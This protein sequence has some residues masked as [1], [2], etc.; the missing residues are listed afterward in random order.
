[1]DR[2]E[3][4]GLIDLRRWKAG[5]GERLHINMATAATAELGIAGVTTAPLYADPYY[6]PEKIVE[7]NLGIKSANSHNFE[8][9]NPFCNF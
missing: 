7:N 4:S 9:F 1:M 8:F 6:M 2:H 5:R 3:A